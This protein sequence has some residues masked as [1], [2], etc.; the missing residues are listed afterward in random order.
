MKIQELG[1]PGTEYT[2]GLVLKWDGRYLFALE[3][4]SNWLEG[5]KRIRYVGIGGHREPGESWVQAVQREAWEEAQCGIEITTERIRCT[6]TE[7]IYLCKDD[8][9]VREMEMDWPEHPPPFFIWSGTFTFH[10]PIR[11][12]HFI[13]IVFHA[14]ALREPNPAAEM[15][16]IIGL[17]EEQVLRTARQPMRL[18]NLLAEGAKLWEAQPI[19]RQAL[20]EPGGTAKFFAM[21]L[22]HFEREGRQLADAKR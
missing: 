16:A 21:L 15:P 4:R 19:P 17:S 13:C 8:G 14:R 12:R 9:S 1:S 6:T 10:H 11:R 22:E 20:L 2:T 7:K 3:P 5:G 18:D